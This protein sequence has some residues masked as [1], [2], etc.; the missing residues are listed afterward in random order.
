VLTTDPQDIK[1]VETWGQGGARDIRGNRTKFDLR[2]SR[3]R[4]VFQPD[5]SLRGMVAGYKPVFD[6]IQSPGIGGVGSALT[7]GIDCAQYLQTLRKYAD[8]IKDPKTGKCSGVSAALQMNAV[9][10]FVND[11]P[12]GPATTQKVVK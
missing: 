8:G 6:V 11:I 12:A 2:R 4:L 7:A 10:A 5:G 9:P 1:L 3:L